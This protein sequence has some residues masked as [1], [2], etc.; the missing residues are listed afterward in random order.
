[1]KPSFY[2]RILFML[3]CTRGW[4]RS[5]KGFLKAC[6][7]A[8]P[9]DVIKSTTTLVVN[10]PSNRIPIKITTEEEEVEVKLP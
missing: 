2:T 10:L 8:H 7:V 1:M 6:A 4:Y 3:C 5:Y 9:G